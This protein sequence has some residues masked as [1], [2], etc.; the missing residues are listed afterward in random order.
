VRLIVNGN[1]PGRLVE[2]AR[3][4]DAPA[5]V[6][7]LGTVHH[8]AFAVDD[9]DQQLDLRKQLVGRGIPVTEVM[10][11]QYFRSIYFREPGGVLFE[12]ATIPPGFTADESLADLGTGLKLPPWEESHRAQIEAGLPQVTVS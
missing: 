9:P 5:A 10:D 3:A 4:P 8:V 6:N 7:G 12:V 11:R 2:L 1:S